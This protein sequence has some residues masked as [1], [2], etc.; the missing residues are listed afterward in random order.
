MTHVSHHEHGSN[1]V[2]GSRTSVNLREW[3]PAP[4]HS[5]PPRL[6]RVSRAYGAVSRSEKI[7]AMLLDFV[8]SPGK[9]G[10]PVTESFERKPPWFDAKTS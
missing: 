1:T 2:L 6:R 4:R 8:G 7:F 9:K 5:H 3:S 10:L